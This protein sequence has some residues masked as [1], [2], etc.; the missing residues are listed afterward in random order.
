MLYWLNILAATGK[1]AKE[2]L[3]DLWNEF[4]RVFYTQFSYEGVDKNKADEMARRVRETSYVGQFGIVS[5]E[6]VSYTDPATGET[7]HTDGIEFKTQD[8]RF[9]FRLSGTGTQGATLRFYAE[10]H[11]TDTAQFD[12]PSREYLATFLEIIENIFQVNKTFDNPKI[13]VAM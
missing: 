9:F 13:T 6:N 1:S 7:V 2:L 10:K 4:G 8:G 5:Q 11:E 3:Y 12:M